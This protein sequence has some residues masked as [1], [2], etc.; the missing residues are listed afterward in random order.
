MFDPVHA[1]PTTPTLPTLLDLDQAAFGAL[2]EPHRRALHLHCYRMLGSVLDAEDA[3]QEA[4]LRAWR[5]RD[6]FEGRSGLGTWLHSIG[7]HICLDLLKR[8]KRRGIPITREA[9]STL[10]QPIPPSVEE[11]VWLE[12]FPD[13]LLPA[14][15]GAPAAQGNDPEQL[16]AAR[17]HIAL[18]FIAVL[19]LLPP[20]QRAVLLLRDVLD[21]QASEVAAHLNMTVAAV[22]SALHRARTTLDERRYS[23]PA[24]ADAP[25]VMLADYVMAWENADIDRLVRLLTDDATFS[26]PPIPSWYQGHEAIRGLTARTVF[27]G[28]AAAVGRWRLLPARANL[29]TAFGLYRLGATPG[30]YHAYGIQVL[31]GRGTAQGTLI[32]D[33]ITF[34]VPSLFAYFNLPLVHAGQ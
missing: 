26:M 3:V 7:T 22:K 27:G 12:P 31:T 2:I 24:P 13:D 8:R 25:P 1:H 14:E 10:E 30:V 6:S 11:P 20:R 9:A 15:I 32:A 5:G 4:F 29:Q 19:H 33:I 28:G 16:L 23:P 18:A 34:R 17:E 21:W